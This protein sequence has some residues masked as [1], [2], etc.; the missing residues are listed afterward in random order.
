MAR[1]DHLYWFGRYEYVEHSHVNRGHC[2]DRWKYIWTPAT[3]KN[4]FGVIPMY[5]ETLDKEYETRICLPSKICD[6]YNLELGRTII[7]L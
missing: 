7:E 1:R 4:G 6:I 2:G 5:D 3:I